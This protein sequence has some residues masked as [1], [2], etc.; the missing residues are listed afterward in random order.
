[1]SVLR[2]VFNRYLISF[3]QPGGILRIDPIMIYIMAV[4]F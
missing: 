2:Y 1:M 3:K 4:R